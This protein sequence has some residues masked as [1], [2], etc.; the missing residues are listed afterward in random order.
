M[1]T[2]VEECVA[3]DLEGVIIGTNFCSEITTPATWL[4]VLSNLKPI[5]EAA[6]G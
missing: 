5:V 2:P 6:K 4:K 3:A 1:T